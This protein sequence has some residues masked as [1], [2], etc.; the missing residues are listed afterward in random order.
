MILQVS[1]NLIDWQMIPIV[2]IYI[3][4]FS[5]V[6]YSRKK[7]AGLKT[8]STIIFLRQGEHFVVK[9]EKNYTS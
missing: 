2:S 5:L 7:Y 3:C 6:L 9:G 1:G 8:E 4:I